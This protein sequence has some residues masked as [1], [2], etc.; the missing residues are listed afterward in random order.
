M[1]S[2][3]DSESLAGRVAEACAQGVPLRIRGSGSKEFYAGPCAGQPLSTRTHT[4]IVHYEPT[5]LVLT[6]RSGTALAAVE[7]VL[8][9]SGQMLGFEP[10]HFGSG[11]TW[12][13]AVACGLSGP[14]RPWSGSVRDAVLGCRIVNGRGEV[15]SFGGQVMK[16][17]AGFD[18]SRLMAGALG[19]LGLLLEISVKVLP[20]PECEMTL[21]FECPF[22][23]GRERMIRW[24]GSGLPVTGLAWDGRL[25]LRL[26]GPEQAVSTAIRRIGGDRAGEGDAIWNGLREQTHDF[27]AGEGDLWRLS[28]P[29]A[30]DTGDLSGS[31]LIDWGGAQRWLRTDAGPA[32]VLAA[33][34]AAGGHARLFR[35]AH[36]PAMRC[37]PLAPALAALH[38]R[39]KA[40]FDPAGILNRGLLPEVF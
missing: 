40:A 31:W 21:C 37:A 29:P 20:R 9:E 3:D 12:G 23:E 32:E 6:A 17:V 26:A 22:A 7:A 33:A 30:A 15:L 36:P 35:S 11:A 39:V 38:R 10:P 18:V 19:T 16:N 8:A 1:H 24:G 27:F 34:Q 14:R 5:E 25:H 13:G 2:Q 28:L 4:G